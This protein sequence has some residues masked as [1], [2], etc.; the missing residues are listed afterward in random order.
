MLPMMMISVMMMLVI[1][2][3]VGD[4]CGDADNGEKL[5][6]DNDEIYIFHCEGPFT[7]TCWG[8]DANEKSS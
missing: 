4:D 6:D 3:M 5:N 8:F 2:M 1:M 7:N